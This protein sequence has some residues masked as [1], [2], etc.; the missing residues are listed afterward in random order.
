MIK[1]FVIHEEVFKTSVLFIIGCGQKELTERIKKYG[2]NLENLGM[3]VCGSVL[4]VKS[5][6]FRI[7]WVENEKSIGEI[8]HEVLH[9]VTRILQDKGVPIKASFED[10]EFGDETAAYLLEFYINRISKELKKK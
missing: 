5:K 7:V 3:Y 4:E 1:E 2:V 10:G 9:L 8:V 6:F